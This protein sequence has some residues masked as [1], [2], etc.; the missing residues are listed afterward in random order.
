MVSISERLLDDTPR[1]IP[2]ETLNIHQ[3]ALKLGDRK[4]RVGI[5]QLNSD[6]AGEVLPGTLGLFESADNVV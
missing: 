1:L 6:R 5:V 2:F 3:Y 4:S